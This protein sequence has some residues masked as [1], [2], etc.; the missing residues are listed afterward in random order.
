MVAIIIAGDVHLEG[1]SG[2]VVTLSDHAE[3]SHHRDIR[4]LGGAQI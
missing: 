1:L 2:N 4:L 3:R